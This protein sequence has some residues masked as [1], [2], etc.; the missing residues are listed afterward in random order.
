VAAGAC[1]LISLGVYF[2]LDAS[3]G[4]FCWSRQFVAS[5]DRIH[6]RHRLQ[7][8]WLRLLMGRLFAACWQ[9]VD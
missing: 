6:G 4:R 8:A 2:L 1:G 9:S 7:A 5:A 3:V